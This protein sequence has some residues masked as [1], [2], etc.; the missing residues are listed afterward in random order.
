MTPSQRVLLR[1]TFERMVPLPRRFG[2]QFYERLFHLDPGLRAIFRGDPD[3]Q[4]TMLV[5]ALTLAVLRLVDEGRASQTTRDLGARHRDYGVEDGDYDTFGEA[6][7]WTFEQRLGDGFTP[8][9]RSAW[10]EAWSEIAAAMRSAGAS[11]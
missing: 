3:R 11:V 7:I 5:N 2:L 10:Q 1:Q 8:E 9:L 6:L 4:A